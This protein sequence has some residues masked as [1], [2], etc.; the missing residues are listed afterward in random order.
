MTRVRRI[1]L[2]VVLGD[3]TSMSGPASSVV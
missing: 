2:S 3:L 1:V